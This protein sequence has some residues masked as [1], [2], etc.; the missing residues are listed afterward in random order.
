M[1]TA[2]RI[3]ASLVTIA[4]AVVAIARL[5]WEPWLCN[6]EEARMA[7]RMEKMLQFPDALAVRVDARPALETIEH[8]IRVDPTVVSRYMMKATLLRILQRPSE[9]ADAYRAALRVDRRPELWYNLGET[10]L[11]DHQIDAAIENLKTTALLSPHLVYQVPEPYYTRIMSGIGGTVT[12][13]QRRQ[14]P[15]MSPHELRLR[16]ARDPW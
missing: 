16:L 9:A 11:A 12:A 10:Q 7:A 13:L 2:L 4:A 6:R 3:A 14:T 5:C 1:K 8:C 15:P